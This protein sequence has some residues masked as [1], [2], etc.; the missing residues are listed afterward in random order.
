MITPAQ[1]QQ[2][3]EDCI[4]EVSTSNEPYVSNKRLGQFGIISDMRVRAFAREIGEDESVGEKAFGHRIAAKE[5]L[6]ITSETIV[7]DIENIVS[8][9]S[10]PAVVP[11]AVA[12]KAAVKKPA[13]K[14]PGVKPTVTSKLA[15][16]KKPKNP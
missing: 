12:S 4:N 11:Q 3:V 5:L 13:V 15:K 14:K 10:V 16:A 7:G 2:I 6:N 1:A 8:A 9:K